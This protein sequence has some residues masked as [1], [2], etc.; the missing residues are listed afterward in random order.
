MSG[1]VHPPWSGFSGAAAS[2][3][4]GTGDASKRAGHEVE[5]LVLGRAAAQIQNLAAAALPLEAGQAAAPP[6]PVTPA[7][8]RP[9]KALIPGFWTP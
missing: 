2:A 7:S 6:L 9:D 4:S 1:F 5:R 3:I 8:P